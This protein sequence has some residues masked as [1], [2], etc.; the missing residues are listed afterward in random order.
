MDRASLVELLD[1]ERK[2][3]SSI[4][5]GVKTGTDHAVLVGLIKSL[6]S[7]SLVS[8]EPFEVESMRLTSEGEE[9]A[10][11]GSPEF[12]VYLWLEAHPQASQGD[13]AE[14]VG[15]SL[16]KVGFGTAMKLGWVSVDKATKLLSAVKI[17]PEILDQ[18]K[19]DLLQVKAGKSVDASTLES[20]KKRKLVILSTLTGYKV[21]A[22]PVFS[23]ETANATVLT[24]LSW[25]SVVAGNWKTAN[26]KEYNLRSLGRD[27]G[28]GHLHPLLKVRS[29]IRK[30]LLYMGFEEM[31]T[32]QWV[33]SAFWN[34]DTLF[35]GQQHPARDAHDTFYL[36]DPEVSSLNGSAE[37]N[38]FDR[39]HEGAPLN[40][41]ILGNFTS[42]EYVT[43][44][45]RIHSEGGFGSTGHKTP[46]KVDEAK[47]NILR[48]HTTAVS[49]RVL[50][51][52]AQSA[53]KR[54]E[55]FKPVKCFSIDRVFRNET[56]D[57]T[58]LAE[59]HQVEGFVA[60]YGL[61]LKHLIGE[62]SEFFR[63]LGMTDVKFKPAYNPYTEP[64]ME[65]FAF[66]PGLNKLIEV[67]NSGI[68]RPEML[69]PMGL[70]EG[71]QVIAWGLS[72][73][74]PCMIQYGIS[75]IR[76]LFGHKMH[77]TGFKKNPLCWF[78]PAASL[79]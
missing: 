30:I 51:A 11:N 7:Q 45:D 69:R 10:Q 46:W 65:I 23:L 41:G 31:P 75:N 8:G 50:Y 25:D 17:A 74:R 44:V 54:G 43:A 29:E 62:I 47:R 55:K 40:R 58:H 56:L 36:L 38:H 24:D 66:H 6:Q 13:L 9:Y 73:E 48:T 52:M 49:A 28:G 59:F 3:E 77:I 39:S 42:E 5:L 53:L 22:L 79:P 68:F 18:V 14:G 34:F 67:G 21:T 15:A 63:R 33:E 4:E 35:Q 16:A 20:L 78:A 27:L 64:S 72:V 70:P 60:D 12:Q 26:F 19:S 2:I 57:A 37:R 76:E 32:N 71:V 61:T 1:R